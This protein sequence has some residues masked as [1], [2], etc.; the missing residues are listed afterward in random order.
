MSPSEI[1]SLNTIAAWLART[2]N[3]LPERVDAVV[4]M[5]SQVIETAER[6]AEWLR[7]GRADWLVCAGG[8]GHATEL[9]RENLR[10]HPRYGF[11][12]EGASEAEL[13]ARVAEA[14][15]VSRSRIRLDETSTNT[16]ENVRESKRILR[17]L[18]FESPALVIIQDPTMQLRAHATWEM[19]WPEAQL[20]SESV[21]VPRLGTRTDVWTEERLTELILGE[22]PRL[23]NDAA[24]YGPLGRGFIASVKIPLEV[25][26]AFEALS[27]SEQ[28]RTR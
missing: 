24:G 14:Q 23:R 20:W 2:D 3:P 12:V 17:E 13:L 21:W 28:F 19:Q 4:V 22:V 26:A 11:E 25:E 15:G 10:R 27:N 1:A 7:D 8:V 6:A 5:G 9:L 16:G 18:G